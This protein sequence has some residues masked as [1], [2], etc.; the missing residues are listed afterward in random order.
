MKRFY[1]LLSALA[2]G[3]CAALAQ[4]LGVKVGSVSYDF[5]AL[6]T[7]RMLFQDGKTLTIAG[8]PF[9]LMKLA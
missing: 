8:V 4:T 6:L 5:S 7:G 3:A 2:L 1:T 9:C